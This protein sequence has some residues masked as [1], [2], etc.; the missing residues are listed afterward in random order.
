MT[1][2]FALLILDGI[3]CSCQVLV[4]YISMWSCSGHRPHLPDKSIEWSLD[5]R[6]S[7]RFKIIQARSLN[8]RWTCNT[9]FCKLDTCSTIC[10]ILAICFQLFELGFRLDHGWRNWQQM[11]AEW[12]LPDIS[13]CVGDT[14]GKIRWYCNIISIPYEW[15][16]RLCFLNITW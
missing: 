12:Q 13:D 1:N 5:L 7:L 6:S 4:Y 10:M 8:L 14:I 2:L 3:G 11:P 16:P 9:S 15:S